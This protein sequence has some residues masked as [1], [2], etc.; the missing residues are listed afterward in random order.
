MGVIGSV[1]VWVGGEEGLLI[2]DWRRHAAVTG[3]ALLQTAAVAVQVQLGGGGA[4][5]GR[6]RQL[7]QRLL[8]VGGGDGHHGWTSGGGMRR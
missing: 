5:R 7:V 2:D 6:K 8:G 4:G 1:V 3:M